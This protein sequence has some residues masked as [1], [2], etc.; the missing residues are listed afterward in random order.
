[1]KEPVKLNY[2]NRLIMNIRWEADPT[3]GERW[4]TI[5]VAVLVLAALT[6]IGFCIDLSNFP[7]SEPPK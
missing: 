1:M 2:L 7:A 6:R 5:I 4:V 3:L